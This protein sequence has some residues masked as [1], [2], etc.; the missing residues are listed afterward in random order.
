MKFFK[1]FKKIYEMG[2]ERMCKEIGE[3]IEEGDKILDLGCGS[4]ILSF[5]IK[6]KFEVE[7]LGIDI[8]D[9]RICQ[10]PFQKY[11]GKK[12]PF[13]QDYFDV[14]LIS[15]VLHHAL[16]PIATLEEAKRVGK[17]IIIFED[18]PENFLGKVRCFF[19]LFFWNA[20]SQKNTKFHFFKEKEWEKI[21]EKMNLK[22]IAK[23]DFNLPLSFL[24]PVKKKIFVLKK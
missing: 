14:V 15:F 10:I 4:G 18:L 6:K 23:K 17:K 22:L 1:L 9:N 13:P 11:D 24:D 5:K 3:F 16:D 2:A 21:F 12:I 8:A 19:H 20:L 7:I